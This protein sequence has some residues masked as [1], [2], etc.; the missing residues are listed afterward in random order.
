MEEFKDEFVDKMEAFRLKHY[1]RC[2]KLKGADLL[3]FDKV[4]WKCAYELRNSDYE[5]LRQYC[6][7]IVNGLDDYMPDDKIYKLVKGLYESYTLDNRP[8]LC[9]KPNLE[10][11][12]ENNVQGLLFD[13]M[14]NLP[15][16]PES[17]GHVNGGCFQPY[18]SKEERDLFLDVIYNSNDA[19]L[20]DVGDNRNTKNLRYFMFFH[21]ANTIFSADEEVALVIMLKF[22]LSLKEHKHK[23]V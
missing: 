14:M 16:Y 23:I 12:S 9:I 5:F 20:I 15:D 3:C 17:I 1:E 10:A 22:I 2:L 13:I 19:S 6:A 4:A 18:Y 11:D 21:K 7:D 8:Y